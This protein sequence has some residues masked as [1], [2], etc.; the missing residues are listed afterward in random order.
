LGTRVIK[1]KLRHESRIRVICGYFGFYSV[2]NMLLYEGLFDTSVGR[3]FV[4]SRFFRKELKTEF[5]PK[6]EN[7]SKKSKKK[8]EIKRKLKIETIT[9]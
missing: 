8:N 7:F 6:K 1:Q 5:A 3:Q 9:S 2:W 4:N